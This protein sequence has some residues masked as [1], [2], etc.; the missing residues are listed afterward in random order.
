MT[1]KDSE[2]WEKDQAPKA[3]SVHHVW[4]PSVTFIIFVSAAMVQMTSSL[5]RPGS[6]G[7]ETDTTP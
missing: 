7:E 6:T 4:Y 3:N 1:L 2:G 5:S